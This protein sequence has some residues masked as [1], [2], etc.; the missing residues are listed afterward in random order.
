MLASSTQV[1]AMFH[2]LET[3]HTN[4]LS[5]QLTNGYERG[6]PSCI[7][8]ICSATDDDELDFDG[9][10]TAAGGISGSRC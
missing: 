2:M 8:C 1:L 5:T 9:S 4:G 3:L 6:D 7:Q 10:T